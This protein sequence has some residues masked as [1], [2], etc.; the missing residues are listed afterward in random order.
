M[1]THP[2]LIRLRKS[3]IDVSGMP[4]KTTNIFERFQESMK[5]FTESSSS[6]SSEDSNVLKS[7]F[8]SPSGPPSDE[9]PGEGRSRSQ[10]MGDPID[11]MQVTAADG[12]QQGRRRRTKRQVLESR[13]VDIEQVLL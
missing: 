5:A 3:G 8:K 13:S 9:V 10:Q 11:M 12:E 6:S 1:T 7:A 2:Y 4:R